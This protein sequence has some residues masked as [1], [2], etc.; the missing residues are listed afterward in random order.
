[1]ELTHSKKLDTTEHEFSIENN[2]DIIE[3]IVYNTKTRLPKT[4]G[5]VSDNMMIVIIVSLVSLAGYGFMK[6]I[7]AKKEND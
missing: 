4:G 6:L 2:G 1:M 3:S 5:L 7:S